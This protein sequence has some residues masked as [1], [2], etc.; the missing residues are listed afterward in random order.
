[1][2]G[3]VEQRDI[4]ASG[5]GA[6]TAC[7]LNHWA[8]LDYPGFGS[9]AA[10][11]RAESQWRFASLNNAASEICGWRYLGP[12]AQY[13]MCEGAIPTLLDP[14]N[15]YFAPR[16]PWCT[17]RLLL[18]RSRSQVLGGTYDDSAL[19]VG[20]GLRPRSERQGSEEGVR[21]SGVGP[22]K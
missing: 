11:V 5:S 7:Q 21:T 18:L 8:W 20:L 19:D 13:D 6:G 22:R 4:Q 14:T 9:Y 3:A 2:V 15:S 1:M 17:C 12:Y 16:C 10:Q